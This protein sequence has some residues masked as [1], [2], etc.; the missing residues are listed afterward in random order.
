MNEERTVHRLEAFSDIVIGFGL[1][2]LGAVLIIDPK[3]MTLGVPGVLAYF[4][5]FAI[6]CSLWYFH[7][8]LFENF[9]VPKTWP[10]VLNFLWLAIVVLL[11]FCAAHFNSVD[12]FTNANLDLLYFGLYAVAYAILAAQTI[13]GMREHPHAAEEQRAKARR[14][15]AF[16]TYWTVVFAWC[17]G[18]VKFMPPTALLGDAIMFTFM[19]AGAGSVVMGIYF[20][21]HRAA[22]ANA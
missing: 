20:K 19:I 17:F 10:I 6:I 18:L 4:G 7:H 15:V 5:A 8:R 16:M 12:A 13:L 2:Q 21:R 14:N 9:F 1:A 3:T 11:V 22:S